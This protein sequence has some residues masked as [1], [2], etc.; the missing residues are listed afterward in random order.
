MNDT[1]GQRI[2]QQ[3]KKAGLSQEALGEQLGVSRQAISKWE[4]DGAIPEID[5][6]IALSRLFQVSIG[7]LLGVEDPQLQ[8][9]ERLLATLENLRP[10]ASKWQTP[11]LAVTAIAVVLSLILSCLAL[12]QSRKALQTQKT[13]QELLT[14]LFSPDPEPSIIKGVT[15]LADTTQDHSGVVYQMFIAPTAYDSGDTA[16]LDIRQDMELIQS[17]PCVYDR[18][19]WTVTAELPIENGYQYTFRLCHADGSEQLQT[20]SQDV[21]ENLMDMM[22]FPVTVQVSQADLRPG[23]LTLMEPS[24]QALLPEIFRI[25]GQ[26]VKW[27]SLELAFTLNEQELYRKALPDPTDTADGFYLYES[28]G[29]AVPIPDLAPGDQIGM[30]LCGSLDNGYTM[31]LRLYTWQLG[32]DGALDPVFVHSAQYD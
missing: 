19:L 12:F 27:S 10:K 1:I 14:Q 4:S 28:H 23:Y 16:Y 22:D 18:G 9:Q 24:I 31:D 13:S 5:K 7:W 20:I 6:L 15:A 2:S 32:Q 11:L 3:R 26:N 17:L 8:D 21:P 30:F 29:F 25:G